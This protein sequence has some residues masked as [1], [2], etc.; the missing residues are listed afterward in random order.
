MT[1]V[2]AGD[3]ILAVFGL[4][5]LLGV[6]SLLVPVARRLRV[7]YTVLLAIFGT[8]VGLVAAFAPT[9]PG[10]VGDL[11]KALDLFGLSS[12]AFFYVFLPP[13]LFSAGLGVNLRR[14][15]DDMGPVILLAVVAVLVCTAVVGVAVYLVAPQYGLVACLVLAAIVATTDS[16]AVVA[17]FRDLGAPTRLSI[18]VEGE[19]LF[20]DAAAIAIFVVL[21]G[22][23]TGEDP[24]F[25]VGISTFLVG[26][27]GG[28][29]FGYLLARVFVSIIGLLR[30]AALTE[31]T[32]TLSLAYLAFVIAEVYLG[33]SGVIAVVTAAIVIGS[34]GRTRISPGVW[35]DLRETWGLVD[36]IATSLIFTFAAMLV[37][38]ALADISGTDVVI[39]A[40]LFL[41]TIIARVA[42]LYGLM[43]ALSLA[44]LSQSISGSYK[45]V[46]VW[47]GLRGAVTIALALAI[48]E[49]PA[50]PQ[51]VQR[52]ILVS[53]VSFVLLTLL[54]M[55][56]TIRPLM[57]GLG[58]NAL[59]VSERALR[60]R[61]RRLSQTRA[62]SR[63]KETVVQI[64]LSAFSDTDGEGDKDG[65]IGVTPDEALV[66]KEERCRFG[67]MALA[68]RERELYLEY[69]QDGLLDRQIA[70]DLR[71]HTGRLIDAAKLGG[72]ERYLDMA[73]EAANLGWR[74]RAARWLYNRMAVGGP[75]S[76]VISVR[77]ETLIIMQL[78]LRDL[79]GFVKKDLIPLIGADVAEDLLTALMRRRKIVEGAIEVLDLQYPAYA[80]MLRTRYVKRVA[81][82]M[83]GREYRQQR[84]HA[85]IGNEVYK[86][87]EQDRL[88]RARALER[89]PDLDLGLRLTSMLQKVSL[90]TALDPATLKR[91]ARILTPRFFAPGELVLRRGDLG[92]CMYFI[93][94]GEVE[95]VLPD[96]CIKL[97]S[98]EFFGEVALVTD[99]PRN[100]DVRA[101]GFCT[102][103]ALSRRDFQ[104]HIR[105]N[106]RIAKE[107]EAT[108]A[109]RA[110]HN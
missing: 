106:K 56:P 87:L 77:F 23:L 100:A 25:L 39:I 24:T 70:D 8:T 6:V 91:L 10:A 52:F 29:A 67:F 98:G 103:L 26:L 84:D 61:S 73:M 88:A 79:V 85:V 4:A 15:M 49:N 71:A 30:D 96:R 60:D 16:S 31:I 33:V 102:L 40:T 45:A 9:P 7:P 28:F 46:L 89:R 82:V 58:L 94:A 76:K 64:G 63:M 5:V 2:I 37:P 69:F 19:S 32:L 59:G 42:V 54:V 27:V 74:L 93:A 18:I 53:A 11:V 109:E 51:E 95:V 34:E 92:D 50:V 1:S 108:A 83:E 35:E 104:Q 47:G 81:L 12:D 65:G 97:G 43:P 20:N 78:A 105:N 90:L 48:S 17:I 22:I 62:S 66:P 110:G 21:V 107:I 99:E 44:K 55:A 14:L 101:S 3:V 13:L 68:G 41:S 72:R 80:E 36:F 38:A 57:S 75:L 86:D